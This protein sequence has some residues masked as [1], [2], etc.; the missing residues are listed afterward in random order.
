MKYLILFLLVILTSFAPSFGQSSGFIDDFTLPNALTGKEFSLKEYEDVPTVIV[1]FTSLQCPYAQLYEARINNLI[2]DFQ[3][4]D[5]RF[6]LINPNN[7]DNSPSDTPEN[8]MRAAQGQQLSVPFLSDRN[9]RVAR[10]FGAEKTPEAFVLSR[11]RNSYKIVYQGAI[12]DNPQVA[13]AVKHHYLR[14]FLKAADSGKTYSLRTV[15]ATG[16]MIKR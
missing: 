7:P 14:D 9:Q 1:I 4:E 3:D 13:K 15:P 12:D 6:V 16:C 8:M 11:Q 5:T 2:D 10:M